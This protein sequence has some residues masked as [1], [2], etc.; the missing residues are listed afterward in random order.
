VC[1]IDNHLLNCHLRV[2]HSTMNCILYV[3]NGTLSISKRKP[4]CQILLSS[5]PLED[6]TLLS[7]L[8]PPQNNIKIAIYIYTTNNKY[9]AATT[10]PG[11]VYCKHENDLGQNIR[12]RNKVFRIFLPDCENFKNYSIQYESNKC[13]Q[14]TQG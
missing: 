7:S 5:L 9:I 8:S 3:W 14:N 10:C 1:T 4:L 12:R 11:I 13:V 6:S 2:A